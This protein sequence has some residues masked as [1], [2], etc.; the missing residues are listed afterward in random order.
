MTKF[1]ITA[2]SPSFLTHAAYD[3]HCA[4]PCSPQL[5]Y[6]GRTYPAVKATL[7][8]TKPGSEEIEKLVALQAGSSTGGMLTGLVVFAKIEG[9]DY[10]GQWDASKAAGTLDQVH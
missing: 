1:N 3:S 2:V 6:G 9:C 4:N 8:N 10:V 7:I 5:E